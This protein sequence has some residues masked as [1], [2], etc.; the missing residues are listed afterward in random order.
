MNGVLS[1]K[2]LKSQTLDIM[3]KQSILVVEENHEPSNKLF[4]SNLLEKFKD[5]SKEQ[6]KGKIKFL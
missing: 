5:L 6:L 2:K 1:T 4:G 3:K